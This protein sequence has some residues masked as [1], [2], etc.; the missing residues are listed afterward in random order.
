MRATF[1]LSIC[2]IKPGLL[3]LICF[4][5][6]ACQQAVVS[7]DFNT[8][9]YLHVLPADSVLVLQQDLVMPP[10]KA[11]VYF[12]H[13]TQVNLSDIDKYQSWCEFE[14]KTLAEKPQKIHADNFQIKKL[15]NERSGLLDGTGPG[16]MSNTLE[17]FSTV[18]YLQSANQP[19]VFRLACLRRKGTRMQTYLNLND[20]QSALGNLITLNIK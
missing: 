6:L 11:R 5:L 16:S 7:I 15:V 2:S 14:V 19:D 17:E 18:L 8:Q 13:G 20:M 4:V 12:Q 1:H 10:A 3:G 9:P